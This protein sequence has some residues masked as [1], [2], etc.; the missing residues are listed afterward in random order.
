MAIQMEKVE[1]LGRVRH[2]EG[3]FISMREPGEVIEVPA[4]DVSGLVLEGVAKRVGQGKATPDEKAAAQLA[5]VKEAEAKAVAAEKKASDMMLAAVEDQKA[6]ADSRK[7]A[8][9]A[10]K[11]RN[12]AIHLSEQMVRDN[13]KRAEALAKKS[14][15]T[16]PASVPPT[17]MTSGVTA[18][19]GT[20]PNRPVTP[21]P[22]R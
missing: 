1:L 18:G 8:D 16:G 6:F 20:N 17:A 2:G 5:E 3:T 22:N 4:G 15:V 12:E 14:E 10:F 11:L 19:E 9:E 13:Q 7:M 21:G